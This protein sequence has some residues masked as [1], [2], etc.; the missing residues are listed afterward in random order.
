MLFRPEEI[1][2]TSSIGDIFEPL[3]E[4]HRHVTRQT[5]RFSSQDDAV[6]DL[7]PDGEAAI[8]T[9]CI[10]PN[11]FPWEKPADR[12]RFE[13]S[14]AGPLLMAIDGYTILGREV[15]EGRKR[16]NEVRTGI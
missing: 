8:Q 15:V 5:L 10:D 14:L 6:S 16:G 4:G 13:S 2:G 11:R 3:P 12:Q 9:R 7:H 1:H